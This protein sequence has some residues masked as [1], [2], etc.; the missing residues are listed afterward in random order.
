MENKNNPR[1]KPLVVMSEENQYECKKVK[2]RRRYDP[3]DFLPYEEQVELFQRYRCHGDMAAYHKLLM[4]YIRLA[5]SIADSFQ[6]NALREDLKQEAVIALAEAINRWDPRRGRL[7]TIATCIIR[8]RLGKLIKRLDRTY[9]MKKE[10]LKEETVGE[11]VE[12]R[13]QV[14]EEVGFNL[15]L[16]EIRARLAYLDEDDR[17]IVLGRFGLTDGE[18]TYIGI[19]SQ[20]G[21]SRSSVE[22]RFRQIMRFLK[23]PPLCRRCGRPYIKST[24]SVYCSDTCRFLSRLCQPKFAVCKCCGKIFVSDHKFRSYCSLHCRFLTTV[25]G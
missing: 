1:S 5:H 24:R 25:L 23:D 10:P 20:L 13:D 19:A 15:N 3:D 4:Q 17:R 14:I 6:V 22:L 11:Y 2:S 21:T 18:T 9:L 12:V 7:T 8:Q 16:E